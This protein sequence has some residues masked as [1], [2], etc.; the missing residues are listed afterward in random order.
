MRIPRFLE[1]TSFIDRWTRHATFLS[2][3][4]GVL[5]FRSLPEVSLRGDLWLPAGTAPQCE[6]SIPITN[7]RP[8]F[9]SLKSW[10]FAFQQLTRAPKGLGTTFSGCPPVRRSRL[11]P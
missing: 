2:R 11:F 3:L 1:Q 9:D 10:S 8:I 7:F 4:R 5:L 6:F